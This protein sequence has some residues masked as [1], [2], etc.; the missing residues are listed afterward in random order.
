M[1]LFNFRFRSA[2]FS[3]FGQFFNSRFV[4]REKPVFEISSL[5]NQKKFRPDLVWFVIFTFQFRWHFSFIF[6]VVFVSSQIFFSNG[7]Q[8]SQLHEVCQAIPPQISIYSR[9]AH[10]S[11]KK[12]PTLASTFCEAVVARSPYS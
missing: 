6:F 9:F 5:K 10:K 3:R 11:T 7:R 1:L 8:R 4:V 2:L 12:I